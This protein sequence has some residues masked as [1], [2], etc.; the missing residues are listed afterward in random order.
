LK[1]DN[2]PHLDS[3]DLDAFK[4]YVRVRRLKGQGESTKK[5]IEKAEEKTKE[6]LERILR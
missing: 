5:I 1:E 2:K 4:Q 3:Y 6:A